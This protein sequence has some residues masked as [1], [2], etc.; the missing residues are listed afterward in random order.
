MPKSVKKVNMQ[1]GESEKSK[2]Y[3]TVLFLSISFFS[4]VFSNIYP[5]QMTRADGYIAQIPISFWFA[6]SLS[7]LVLCIL[8]LLTNRPAVSLL[9]AVIFYLIF[10]SYQFFFRGLFGGDYNP[11]ARQIMLES[12]F[13]DPE[14]HFNYL[15]WPNMYISYRIQHLILGYEDLLTNIELAF[16]FFV[17]IFSLSVWYFSYQTSADPTYAFFGSTLFLVIVHSFLNF[18]SIPQFFALTLLIFLFSVHNREG[19]RWLLVKLLLFVSLALSHPM[20]YIFYIGAIFF[21]P[22]VRGMW[23]SFE[24]VAGEQGRP[25][26]SV[27]ASAITNPLPFIRHLTKN[28]YVATKD[29]RWLFP[30]VLILSIY[31]T[32][33]LYRFVTWQ[34]TMISSMLVEPEEHS[35]T[36]INQL[37][38]IVGIETADPTSSGGGVSTQGGYYLT[39]VDISTYTTSVSMTIVSI[40]G[41][42]LFVLFLINDYKDIQPFHIAILVAAI[43]YFLAGLMFDILGMRSFQVLFLPF[44][45]SVAALQRIDKRVLLVLVIVLL[46]ISPVLVANSLN[47]AT[48]AAGHSTGDYYTEVSGKW[49]TDH[50]STP[51]LQPRTTTY[52]IKTRYDHKIEN[53]WQS[54]GDRDTNI[55][56]SNS[57]HLIQFDYRLYHSTYYF[58]HECNF[59]EQP[60]VYNNGNPVMWDQGGEFTCSQME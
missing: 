45:G 13:I 1:I 9:L 52:P 22:I 39:S 19:K 49:I 23:A 3:F 21:Y 37:L 46:T 28:T 36:F 18:Q 26:Y 47:N 50:G 54:F 30:T 16:L 8:A 57:A 7:L 25:L 27:L 4:I 60:I 5:L 58:L 10:S 14:I 55:I 42:L 56:E 38:N 53:S 29:R 35:A 40:V 20:L 2:L 51:V 33:Y 24:A 41:L 12:P 59:N 44:I 43:G 11:G 32:F 48:L 6:L 17:I 31:L 34:T 15:Q